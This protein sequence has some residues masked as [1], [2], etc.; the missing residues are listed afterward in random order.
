MAQ[1]IPSVVS[2]NAELFQAA[3]ERQAEAERRRELAEGMREILSSL[4]SDQPLPQILNNIVVRASQLL[5][6]NAGVIRRM[7]EDCSLVVRVVNYNM[8]PELVDLRVL[9][10]APTSGNL[11]IAGRQ[12]VII[13]DFAAYTAQEAATLEPVMREKYEA[14]GRE[15]A[16]H[17]SSLLR[18][19]LVARDQVYGELA[20]FYRAPR[21]FSDDDVSLALAIA[22]QTALAIENCLLR[23]QAADVAAIA[24]RA[25]LAASSTTPSRSQSTAS[26]STLK[27]LPGWCPPASMPRL[28]NTCE[29]CEIPRKRRCGRCACSSSSCARPLWNR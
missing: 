24:E 27:L 9:P 26:R 1:R 3:L 12:P 5:G 22:D 17:F 21:D 13:P 4:N 10:V 8:P 19:P 11:A 2:D 20:L 28:P 18:V 16:A 14:R 6:A 15:I 29:I 7:E 23:Q 25:R